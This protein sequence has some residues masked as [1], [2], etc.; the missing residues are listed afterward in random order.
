[1]RLVNASPYTNDLNNDEKEAV[2][3]FFEEIYATLDTINVDDFI[4]N[5]TMYLPRDEYDG[6][7]EEQK[8]DVYI[9]VNDKEK[10]YLYV[11]SF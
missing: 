3:D 4:V 1:M 10:D 8:E 6:M 9:L 11:Q 7:S 5:G 2:M